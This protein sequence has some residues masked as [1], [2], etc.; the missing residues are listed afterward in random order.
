MTLVMFAEQQPFL[1]IEVG[2]PL[3]HLIAQQRLLKEL[4]LQPQRH[5]HAE[6]VEAARREGKVCLEQALELQERLVVESYVVDV[7]KLEAGRIQAVLHGVF[8]KARVVLLAREAL[9]LG[10]TDQLTIRDQRGGAVMVEGRDSQDP[11]ETFPRRPSA[12]LR[13]ACR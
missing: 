2:L 7:G 1:P 11:H 9:L 4:F 8:R 12:E 3:L 10:G 5:G 13:T 6:G